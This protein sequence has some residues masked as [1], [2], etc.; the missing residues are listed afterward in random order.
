MFLIN[1]YI[2]FRNNFNHIFHKL[3]EQKPSTTYYL[4]TGSDRECASNR[5]PVAIILSA[6]VL[7]KPSHSSRAKIDPTAS[8]LAPE[9]GMNYDPQ[10]LTAQTAEV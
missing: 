2:S 1:F 3:R 4:A 5:P 10:R 6:M 9:F 7:R 8:L